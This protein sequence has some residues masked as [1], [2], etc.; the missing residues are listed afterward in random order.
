VDA[1]GK[2]ISVID[3]GTN[4]K[5]TEEAESEYTKG[6]ISFFASGDCE[7]HVKNVRIKRLK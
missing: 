1:R 2:N 4:K 7:V 3:L 6:P 5:R